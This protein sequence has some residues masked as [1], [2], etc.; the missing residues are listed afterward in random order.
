M[1]L[2]FLLIVYTPVKNLIPQNVNI[3][4]GELID[5][6][7]KVDSLEDDLRK[8]TLYINVI[9]KILQGEVIDSF[10]TI[11]R[12]STLVFDN[13]DLSPSSA[14]STLREQVKNEDLY[15]IPTSHEVSYAGMG[16]FV[17]DPLMV[18]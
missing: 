10:V 13:V 8:K 17:L 15:N 3:K 9:H 1:V 4:K 7:V 11:N 5:V 12:D 6:M 16:D 2:C 18:W 14:D